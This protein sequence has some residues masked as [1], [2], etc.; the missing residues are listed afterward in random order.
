M[1]TGSCGNDNELAIFQ[2]WSFVMSAP[3]SGK[4]PVGLD[5]RISSTARRNWVLLRPLRYK[6][7]LSSFRLTYPGCSVDSKSRVKVSAI[8][9]MS[10]MQAS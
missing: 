9:V 1:E 6:E 5:C 3:G 8:E 10:S 2:A 7:L 4:R